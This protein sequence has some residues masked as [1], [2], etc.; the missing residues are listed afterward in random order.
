MVGSKRV[1]RPEPLERFEPKHARPLLGVHSVARSARSM[2]N[3]Y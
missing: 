3:A 2:N 1:E